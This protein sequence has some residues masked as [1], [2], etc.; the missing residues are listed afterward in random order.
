[1]VSQAKNQIETMSTS[2][3][4]HQLMELDT[5]PHILKAYNNEP[6]NNRTFRIF[7]KQST[8]FEQR[9]S[10][11]ACPSRNEQMLVSLSSVAPYTCHELSTPIAE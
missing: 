9:M 7:V 2:H 10:V 3:S 11:K 8:H 1:M 5:T 4:K 6:Q